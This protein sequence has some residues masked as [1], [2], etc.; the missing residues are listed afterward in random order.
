MIDGWRGRRR[1]RS[2]GRETECFHLVGNPVR[3]PPPDGTHWSPSP[4]PQPAVSAA[5]SDCERVKARE[6]ER[7]RLPVCVCVRVCGMSQ[8]WMSLR[9]TDTISPTSPH[10]RCP[11]YKGHIPGAAC[12]TTPCV[13]ETAGGGCSRAELRLD[14]GRMEQSVNCQ[15]NSRRKKKTHTNNQN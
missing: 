2:R 6:R 9:Q 4:T 3:L 11:G 13:E 1:G 8:Q 10:Q 7:R 15:F 14:T 5:S 12:K